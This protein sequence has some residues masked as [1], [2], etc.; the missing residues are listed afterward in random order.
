MKAVFAILI[1][2]S[3][4][5]NPKTSL[6]LLKSLQVIVTMKVILE[7]TVLSFSKL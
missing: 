7:S 2:L 1:E 3:Q 4:L 6:E 5:P